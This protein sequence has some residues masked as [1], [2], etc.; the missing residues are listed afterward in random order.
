MFLTGTFKF[1][2]HKKKAMSWPRAGT[3]THYITMGFSPD[4]KEATE[5]AL[6]D[7]IDFSGRGKTHD[8]VHAVE[9]RRGSGYN[10]VGERQCWGARDVSEEHLFHSFNKVEAFCSLLATACLVANAFW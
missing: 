6:L 9:R 10:P 2:V 5:H 8:T 7:M 3:P 4:L 1:V